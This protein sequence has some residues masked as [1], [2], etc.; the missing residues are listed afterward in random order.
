MSLEIET[1]LCRAGRMDN[2]SYL[3]TDTQSNLCAV[4]DPSEADPIIARCIELGKKPSYILNT[5]HHYDHTDANITLKEYFGAKVI[6]AIYDANR[7]P[8]LDETVKDGDTWMLGNSKAEI[9]LVD[10]H[11]IG[12]I[13]WYFPEAK[14]VFTGDTLFNLCIGGLFEGTSREMFASL[15]KIRDLP[16]D[17]LFY[18]GHEYTM[19]G[20]AYAAHNDPHNQVL[21]D[22]INTAQSRLNQGLPVGPI[23]LEV[24]KQCNP[25]LKAQTLG[26]LEKLLG[27]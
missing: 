15:N 22:Y 13:L 18:P 11:T 27:Q 25:Y 8:G 24:E 14:A 4:I 2:Y 1:I 21:R 6:G 23:T 26:E 17:T 5:H 9:I 10:G 7:I 16:G 3:I 19:H 20:M 12:H